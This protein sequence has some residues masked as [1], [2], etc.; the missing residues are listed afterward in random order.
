MQCQRAAAAAPE[1]MSG[2]L[3]ALHSCVKQSSDLP[4]SSGLLLPVCRYGRP[5]ATDAEVEWAAKAAA[6]HEA[7]CD[8]FPAGY[9]TLVRRLLFSCGPRTDEAAG[10]RACSSVERCL[11]LV[12]AGGSDDWV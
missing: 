1:A 11:R 3:H 4:H 7:I 5:S 8:H 10:H 6:L 12:A 2:T 9:D